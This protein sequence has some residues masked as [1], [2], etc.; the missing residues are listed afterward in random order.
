[1]ATWIARLMRDSS[2]PD[3]TLARLRGGTPGL[4]ATWNSIVSRPYALP[5]ASGSNA[6]AKLP[7][8]IASV[9]IAAVISRDSLSA[10][11]LRAARQFLRRSKIVLL[12]GFF[13]LLQFGQI[14]IAAQFRQ[15]RHDALQCLVQL[16]RRDAVFARRI[17]HG[18]D[19]LLLLAQALRVGIQALL[20]MA[21]RIDG[22]LQFGLRAFQHLQRFAQA[23]IMCACRRANAPSMH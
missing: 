18:L 16:L 10:A 17:H 4:A 20:V 13:L 5:S 1:M 23:G 3:A 11:F 22:L 12:R 6:T 19:A 15:A 14:G 2:P 7:P 8:C 21:Q 9:C